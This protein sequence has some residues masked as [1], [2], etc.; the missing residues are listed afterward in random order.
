MRRGQAA[1][2]IPWITRL[3]LMIVAV[4]IIALLVRYYANRDVQESEMAKQ[5]LFYR[6]YY[7]DII[8]YTDEAT[9]RVYPGVVDLQHFTNERL[10][11][12]FIPSNRGVPTLAACLRL[13]EG[14]KELKKIC[15]DEQGYNNFI[16]QARADWEGPGGATYHAQTLPVSI[17]DGNTERPGQLEITI[18]RS[19][20]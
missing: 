8:M 7:D 17:K 3:M 6:L 12:V 5:A 1:E 4:V 15:T 11:E 9:K 19:N 16:S 10:Q 13:L 14:E 2:V 20:T 18:V